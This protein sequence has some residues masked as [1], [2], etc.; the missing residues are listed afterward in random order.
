MGL[1]PAVP[2]EPSPCR[3]RRLPL[4]YGR[5]DLENR[6]HHLFEGHG[7]VADCL[8][9]VGHLGEGLVAA[10]GDEDRVV[11]E[12]AGAAWRPDQS[13]VDPALEPFDMAVGPG[14]R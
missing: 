7:A 8:L 10:F 2:T 14:E 3:L 5:G 1:K 11:A 13:A 9:R 6:C 4:P 12:A